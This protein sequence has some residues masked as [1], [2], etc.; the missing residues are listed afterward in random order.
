MEYTKRFVSTLMLG[1]TVTSFLAVIGIAPVQSTPSSTNAYRFWALLVTAGRNQV[2][3]AMFAG[4]DYMYHVI[5]EHYDFDGIYYLN[6]YEGTIPGVN[7]TATLNNT[8][9]AITDWL[10]NT[11]GPKDIIFIYFNVHGGGYYS[12]G[13]GGPPYYIPKTHNLDGGQPDSNGDEVDDN[14]DESLGFWN[15][16]GWDRYLDDTLAAD[17]DSLN[18]NYSTL[19]LC[20][21]SC[22]GGGIIDDIQA[23]PRS[24]SRV[25][26]TATSETL[27]AYTDLDDHKT[28]PEEDGYCEWSEG[29][30]D[31]LHGN[32]TYWDSIQREVVHQNGTL[33]DPLGG[34][35]DWN[36]DGRVTMSEAFSWAT[37]EDD[38]RNATLLKII[39][40]NPNPLLPVYSVREEP[41]IDNTLLAH[42]IWFPKKGEHL[43]NIQTRLTDDTTLSGVEFSIDNDTTTY[44]TPQVVN[45]TTGNHT[46][47]MQD[48]F[49]DGDYE[50]TFQYW[51]YNDSSDNPLT[52]NV[53]EHI[54]LTA[55]YA[56][57][58]L[59]D[60]HYHGNVNYPDSYFHWTY[61]ELGYGIDLQVNQTDLDLMGMAYGMCDWAPWG[62]GEDLYNP[63]ADINEDG[64][65]DIGD[66]TMVCLY[67]RTSYEEHWDGYKYSKK[68]S[69]S[70]VEE[71]ITFYNRTD[72]AVD[73]GQEKYVDGE[74]VLD[75]Y[76]N[77]DWDPAW[78][79]P[80]GNSTQGQR[81]FEEGWFY[82]GS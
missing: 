21:Q 60:G 2:D 78:A 53:L 76:D 56:K 64:M 71:V 30:I 23:K 40:D 12:N 61:I 46:I 8:R 67:F 54:S 38:G 26:L 39:I 33:E 58:F 14:Y 4:G 29:F 48:S 69:G 70:A 75:T 66:V 22:Y 73:W 27:P 28:P 82:F 19:I 62:V 25:I 17:I 32:N 55:Y 74:K 16:S 63:D 72:F 9:S 10:Y 18:G 20:T 6:N 24:E 13:G 42:R 41:Q 80:I 50:Y 57:T 43:L 45:V 47:E 5:N 77:A 7:A 81:Y 11:S 15:G 36:R 68:T 44:S 31:A 34:R 51:D 35:P 59:G 3:N 49:I 65:V 1:I 52:V 79:F 37:R